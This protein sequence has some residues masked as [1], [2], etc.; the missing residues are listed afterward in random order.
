[1][2][3][4]FDVI[5]AGAGPG[6]STVATLLAQ[7]G[8]H[9][10]LFEKEEFPRFKIGESLLPHSM[11]I[12]KES[13]VFEKINSGQY[14]KKY[15]ASFISWDH[16]ESAL[17]F[18]FANGLDQDHAFAFEVPRAP[19]DLDLLTH[20]K[21]NGVEVFQPIKIE[22][23]NFEKEKVSVHTTKESFSSSYFVDAS[24]R[25]ALLGTQFKSR[26]KNPHFIN[27]IAVYNH[28][29]GV[30][31]DI[32]KSEGDIIIGILPEQ[33]WSW[34][35]PFKGE[36]TSVGIVFSKESFKKFKNE[37]DKILACMNEHPNFKDIMK[38][39]TALNK[40]GQAANYSYS[41]GRKISDRWIML[42]DAATFL[43][44]VFS[45]GVHISLISSRMVKDVV[46]EAY[47]KQSLLSET[48]AGKNYEQD[49]QK[50]VD[51][52]Q[53]LLLI[54]Y[55]TAFFQ[56]MKKVIQ[57]EAVY[58]AFTSAFSGDM[59]NDQNFLFRMGVLKDGKL[60]NEDYSL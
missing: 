14:I 15:G 32:Q 12:L 55:K 25:S 48:V 45:S 22:Q 51:R 34:H 60:P 37:D 13:G 30:S 6:G 24:G 16:P 58:K 43:D 11:D 5:V 3:N 9:V 19:F 21:E 59:W 27:N 17:Y 56:H 26:E 39:A 49:L 50:G 35:I 8:L 29:K 52:F 42:G 54:F 36:T 18:E 2:T 41:S 28:Y 57:T 10:A 7:K 23:V 46:L 4:H 33:S 47:Q 31:R 44:P 38:N 20:A 40:E 53:S 1:M